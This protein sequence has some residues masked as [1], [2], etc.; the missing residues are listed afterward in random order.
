MLEVN[1][2]SHAAYKSQLVS[3]RECITPSVVY[4]DV[5]RSLCR[6]HVPADGSIRQPRSVIG[7]ST[8]RRR[9]KKQVEDD[10]DDDD[11]STSTDSD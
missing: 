6:F 5:S 9:A 4:D 10:E 2:P 1:G 11:G 8:W 7:F 3:I